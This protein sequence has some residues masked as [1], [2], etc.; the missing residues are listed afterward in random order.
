MPKIPVD[1][2]EKEQRA[3]VKY[4]IGQDEVDLP[5][6]TQ[7]RT[8]SKGET[9]VVLPP[10]TYMGGPGPGT[11]IHLEDDAWL[12]LQSGTVLENLSVTEGKG[13]AQ[14]IGRDAEQ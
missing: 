13:D 5:P 10:Y 4:R 14:D 11:E 1:E 3:K 9:Y 7:F 6:G 2:W 12:V 8:G